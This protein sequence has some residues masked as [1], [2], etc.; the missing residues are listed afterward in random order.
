MMLVL[1]KSSKLVILSEAKDL[2][3]CGTDES[4]SFPF[5]QAQGQDEQSSIS[6]KITRP[7]LSPSLRARDGPFCNG[8]QLPPA[9]CAAVPLE[10]SS[11][12]E[13][14]LRLAWVE[15]KRSSRRCGR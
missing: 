14:A 1:L 10:P 9:G 6:S 7:A 13:M 12:Q 3:S 2:L 5:G 11:G 8:H 4:R 15:G